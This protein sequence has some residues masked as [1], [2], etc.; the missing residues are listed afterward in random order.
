[1]LYNEHE[2]RV[3]RTEKNRYGITGE[4]TDTFWKMT[5]RGLVPTAK[6]E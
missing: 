4:E 1:M 5:E 2:T 3:L 6:L